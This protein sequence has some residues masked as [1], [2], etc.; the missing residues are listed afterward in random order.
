LPKEI[1]ELNALT[2]LNVSGN[3]LSELPEEIGNLKNLEELYLGNTLV[4]KIPAAISGCIDLY[5]LNL[6][7]SK[8]KSLPASMKSMP[9]LKWVYFRE[10]DLTEEEMEQVNANLPAFINIKLVEIG[11]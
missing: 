4:E 9:H 11:K 10:G 6:V 8:V 3:P 5:T 2:G 7:D 1:G